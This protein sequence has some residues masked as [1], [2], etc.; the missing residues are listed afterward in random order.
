MNK[1]VAVG[2]DN[3]PLIKEG[4]NLGEVIYKALIE[5]GISLEDGDI[6]VVTEK[7]V[8]KSEGRVIELSCISPSE[9]AKRLAEEIGKDPRL[10]EIILNESNEIVKKGRGF[11]ISETKHGFICANAGID[12]SNV[13]N[14]KVKL[15]PTDPD[16]SAEKIRRFLEK[17]FKVKV[18]VIISDSWGRPFR[19]GSVGVAIG[20]SGIDALKDRRGDVDLFGKKLK[21][22]RVAVGDCIASLGI[23]L[24][25]EAG[26]K[27]PVVIIR[28]L[29]KYLGK[30]RAS[31][32]IRNKEEDLFR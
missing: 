22:T 29:G 13:E 4:Q 14:G 23:L 15:L 20:A 8:A 28:G 26:E 9:K 11:I 21:S 31:D 7:I 30:G 27:I 19:K 10:I 17:K 6:I 25:G 1:I 2:L 12:Q 24:M 3:L 18:G 32:L 5:K 16:R